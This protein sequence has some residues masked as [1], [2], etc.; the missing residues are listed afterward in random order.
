M[1]F[2]AF[3]D[4][5]LA[6]TLPAALAVLADGVVLTPKLDRWLDATATR[7][8]CCLSQSISDFV[9]RCGSCE[10]LPFDVSEAVEAV[11][12]LLLPK[13]FEWLAMSLP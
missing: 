5:G 1:L 2:P 4:L 10:N 11:P 9:K 12:E 8:D 7:F 6:S 13:D 3:D